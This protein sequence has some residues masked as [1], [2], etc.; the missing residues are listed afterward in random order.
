VNRDAQAGSC[1]LLYC[2]GRKSLCGLGLEKT[3]GAE[4]LPLQQT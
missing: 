3:E 4:R 1:T 2:R